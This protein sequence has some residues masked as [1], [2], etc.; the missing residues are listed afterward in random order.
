[1]NLEEYHLSNLPK[2]SVVMPSYNQADFIERSILSVLNQ[3]YPNIELIVMDGGS[4]DGS[5]EIIKKYQDRIAFW[6]SESDNGQAHAIN[7]GLAKATGEWVGWQNSDDVYAP[8]AI[9]K[10]MQCAKKN[11][12]AGIVMGDMSMID[13]EDSLIRNIR[14]I[15]PSYRSILAEGMVSSNQSSF[16]KRSLQSKAGY[17]DERYHYNFDY[18]WFLR[19][20]SLTTAAHIPVVVASIRVHEQTKTFLHQPEF[21]RENA[22]ILEGRRTSALVRHLYKLRRYSIHVLKGQFLHL[23][24]QL[25][26]W[27]N[28]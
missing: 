12:N 19:L 4:T 3:S 24:E 15:R 10:L 16:W 13:A 21:D 22:L 26:Y 23:Y 9:S 14:Y 25:Q 18:E 17:L 5:L 7:K 6:I 28:K 27:L 1:M 11:P 2:V 20:L 8:D